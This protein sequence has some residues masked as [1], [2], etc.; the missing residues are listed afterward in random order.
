MIIQVIE[1]S[2]LLAGP[3]SLALLVGLYLGRRVC[4]EARLLDEVSEPMVISAAIILALAVAGL[5]VPGLN[6]LG[7]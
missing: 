7:G 2:V 1:L 4:P 6:S 5:I 3:F